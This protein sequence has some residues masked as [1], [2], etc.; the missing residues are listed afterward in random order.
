V[1]SVRV[2]QHGRAELLHLGERGEKQLRTI[3]KQITELEGCERRATDV[4]IGQKLKT[5]H[6]QVSMV[7][8]QI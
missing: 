4:G 6:R 2:V 7:E 8:G 5:L 1:T 3:K